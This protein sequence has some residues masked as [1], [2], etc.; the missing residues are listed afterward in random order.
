MGTVV[1]GDLARRINTNSTGDSHMHLRKILFKLGFIGMAGLVVL[2][3]GGPV[4]Q[5][6]G[7]V[8]L[9][10]TITP[11]S[12]CGKYE[13]QTANPNAVSAINN[14]PSGSTI[15]ICPG[16]YDLNRVGALGALTINGKKLTIKRAVT[17]GVGSRPTLLLDPDVS[18][19]LN[20]DDST[21]S[22]EGIVLDARTNTQADYIG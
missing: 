4:S 7:G 12:G 2:S 19:G 13:N 11:V 18:Q 3:M 14:A 16:T 17:S 1:G 9:V 21:L 8:V 22:I 15:L 5:A 6:A 20:V 10:A